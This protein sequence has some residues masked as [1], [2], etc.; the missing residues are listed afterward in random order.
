MTRREIPGGG[1]SLGAE[2][3]GRVTFLG[4]GVRWAE[5]WGGPLSP[6]WKVLGTQN[7]GL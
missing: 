3:P 4:T 1:D 2:M 7:W 6:G 5:G